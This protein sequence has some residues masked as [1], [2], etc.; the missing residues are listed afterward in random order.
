MTLISFQSSSTLISGQVK[1]YYKGCRE[2]T[3]AATGQGK[4]KKKSWCNINLCDSSSGDHEC[5]LVRAF[6]LDPS[7]GLP[8]GLTV[9]G[10][11]P[12]RAGTVTTEAKS[13][14]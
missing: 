11:L 5:L 14:L 3:V 9:A 4:K 8:E 13:K 2:C 10:S 7:G 12:Y 6:G 1:Q